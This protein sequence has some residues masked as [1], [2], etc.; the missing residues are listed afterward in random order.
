VFIGNALKQHPI[1]LEEVT[2][3]IRSICFC[4]VLLGRIDERDHITKV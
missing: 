1:G 2:D 3:G 4:G